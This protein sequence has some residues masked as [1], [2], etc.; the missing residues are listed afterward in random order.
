MGIFRIALVFRIQELPRQIKFY[1][2]IIFW[3]IA[4]DL[5]VI[6][7]R[8][9]KVS[10]TQSTAYTKKAEKLKCLNSKTELSPCVLT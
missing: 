9:Y 6:L 4:S 2:T 7:S 8:L 5:G 10:D 1:Q 3:T